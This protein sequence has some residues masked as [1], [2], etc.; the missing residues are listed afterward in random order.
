MPVA[1]RYSTVAGRAGSASSGG[2]DSTSVTLAL[3][4]GVHAR[5]QLLVGQAHDDR[6]RVPGGHHAQALGQL[7]GVR[8]HEGRGA[9]DVGQRQAGGDRMGDDGAGVRRLVGVREQHVAGLERRQRGGEVG[10][11]RGAHRRGDGQVDLGLEALKPPGERAGRASASRTPVAGRVDDGQA[12]EGLLELRVAPA[13]ARARRAARRRGR[14]RPARAAAVVLPAPEPPTTATTRG[15]EP[16]GAMT[17]MR[18]ATAARTSDLMAR[19]EAKGMPWRTASSTAAAA[20]A[21][22][23]PAAT[24]ASRRAGGRG[25]ATRPARSGLGAAGGRLGGRGDREREARRR[26]PAERRRPRRAG[27]AGA[28]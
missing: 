27:S 16:I 17:G 12:V 24:S 18:R 14:R 26:R 23:R 20:K 9:G 10:G 19:G 2:T 13:S 1:V 25:S 4:A 6:L 8:G 15:P 22:V 28:G 11:G 7:R 21:G 3:V 5:R